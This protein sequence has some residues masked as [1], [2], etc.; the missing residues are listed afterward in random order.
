[1]P[2]AQTMAF[3]G[4]VGAVG[5]VGALGALINGRRNKD[6]KVGNIGKG[7]I[8]CSLYPFVLAAVA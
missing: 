8:G 4:V 2:T 3:V 1:M 6:D 7:F 5:A